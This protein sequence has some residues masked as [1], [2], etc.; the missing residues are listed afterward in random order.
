MENNGEIKAFDI[1]KSKL[2]LI[3]SGAERLGIDIIKAES[4][5]GR[6]PIDGL[7]GWADRI[8]CDVPCSG[9]GVIAK[10][11]DI[12]YKDISAA[13]ALP[14]IQYGILCTAAQYLK[15]GG[16]MIYSTCTVLPEE[17]LDNV[18][19]FLGSHSDE[20]ELVPI[21]AGGLEV[22]E[23]YVTLMPHIHGTDGFFICKLRRK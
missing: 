18:K 4:H 2:P 5:D 21:K 8:I 7:L 10:K 9:Y 1:S 19:R 20:F 12:R 23:G 17:N 11:P 6:I 3:S 13:T 16:V 14:E 22:P 15:K